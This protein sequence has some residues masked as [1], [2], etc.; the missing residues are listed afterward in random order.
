MQIRVILVEENENN[1]KNSLLTYFD[2]EELGEEYN[3]SDVMKL[4]ESMM[5]NNKKADKCHGVPMIYLE[6]NTDNIADTDGDFYCI[7]DVTLVV[8]SLA[9][10]EEKILPYIAVYVTECW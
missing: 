4:L 3:V 8:P 9:N 2:S 6:V 1:R 5:K 10:E 7:Q